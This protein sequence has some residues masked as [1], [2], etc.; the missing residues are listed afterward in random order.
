[1]RS[2]SLSSASGVL[3]L[4]GGLLLFCDC[5]LEGCFEEEDEEDEI[6]AELARDGRELL[7]GTKAGEF[8]FN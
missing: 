1:M 2:S 3:N 7:D 6:E 8:G 5:F 4:V